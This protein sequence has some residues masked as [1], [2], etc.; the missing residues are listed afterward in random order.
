MFEAS[1]NF[2]LENV[3]PFLERLNSKLQLNLPVE[4]LVQ[5]TR[6]TDIDTEQ[7]KA[8]QVTFDGTNVRLEYRVFMD[9]IDAPDLYFFTSSEALTAAIN[10]QL[11]EFADELGL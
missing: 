5:M 6:A 1:M 7:S 11:A 10:G 2:D 3:R 4:K 9:D 8:I